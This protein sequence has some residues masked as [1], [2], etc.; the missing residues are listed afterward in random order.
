MRKSA[1]TTVVVMEVRSS[2]HCCV[3]L[4]FSPAENCAVDVRALQ[5]EKEEIVRM[6]ASEER[7]KGESKGPLLSE[8]DSPND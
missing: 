1:F 5:E 2:S 6:P 3:G 7:R 8:R 4:A